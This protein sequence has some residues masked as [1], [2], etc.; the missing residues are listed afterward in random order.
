MS[1]HQVG[2]PARRLSLGA[3]LLMLGL[4]AAAVLGVRT[5]FG[6]VVERSDEWSLASAQRVVAGS[7]LPDADKAAL[8][9]DLERLGAAH[10][11]GTIDYDALFATLQRV[12]EGPFVPAGE[13]AAAAR[14]DGLDDAGRAAFRRASASLAAQDFVPDGP[15]ALVEALRSG[16]PARD[17]IPRAAELLAAEAAP[18]PDD[19]PG[20]DPAAAFR[21]LVDE[22]L[23]GRP[24]RRYAPR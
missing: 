10:A 5:T 15:K 8:K 6:W 11:A 18:P 4:V 24:P 9:V 14:Q 20:F 2:D 22:T 17:L 23:A 16:T 21:V 1:A 7:S 13:L 3:G 12:V 19:A